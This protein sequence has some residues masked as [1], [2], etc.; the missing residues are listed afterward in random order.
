MKN[1]ELIGVVDAEHRLTA[2]VPP[3]V[4][5]G[6]VRL[7][8]EIPTPDDGESEEAWQQAIATLWAGQWSDPR[9]DLYSLCEGRPEDEPR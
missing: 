7:L 8:V 3:D 4:P 1:I 6:P 5:P 2:D 9:E